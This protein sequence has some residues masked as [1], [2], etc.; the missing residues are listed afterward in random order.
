MPDTSTLA[1]YDRLAADFAAEWH[2]QPAPADLHELVRQYFR[3]GRTADIGCGSGRECAWLAQNG[4]ETVGFDASD[5]LIAEARRRYPALRFERAALPALDGVAPDS[6]TNVLC[7]TVIMHLDAS[8]IGPSVRRLADILEAGGTLYLSW[9]VTEGSDRRD[10]HGRLYAAF[11]PAVVIDSLSPAEI[12]LDERR[13]SA[14]SGKAV[15]R[16]V[17]RKR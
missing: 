6:F 1:A 15:H 2:A 11:D 7:E 12:L 9:R 4:Y 10:E 8:L 5:G 13:V 14:S 17:A 16:V 3:P